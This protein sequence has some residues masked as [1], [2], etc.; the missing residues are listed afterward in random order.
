MRDEGADGP[1]VVGHDESKTSIEQPEDMSSHPEGGVSAKGFGSEIK[2]SRL[3]T[4][5][6]SF[7]SETLQRYATIQIKRRSWDH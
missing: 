5:V 1:K 6:M 7:D 2:P 3:R 4:Y